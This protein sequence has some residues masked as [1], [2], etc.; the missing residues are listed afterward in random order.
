MTS[1]THY[2]K[3]IFSGMLAT[4]TSL[5][6]LSPAQ[7]E[8]YKWVDAQGITHYSDER[9]ANKTI[10]ITRIVFKQSP[11]KRNNNGKATE[12]G[13]QEVLTL[14]KQSNQPTNPKEKN[15]SQTSATQNLDALQQRKTN[16]A[17]GRKR[18]CEQGR[19][20]LAILRQKIPLYLDNNEQYRLNWAGDTYTG[21]RNYLDDA[22]RETAIEKAEKVIGE[23]CSDPDDREAQ[24]MARKK[25]AR[26]EYCALNRAILSD[27]QRADIKASARQLTTQQELTDKYCK[28]NKMSALAE[29]PELLIYPR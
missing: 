4:Y 14:D 28:A 11:T 16:I 25:W 22:D 26:S 9:P 2:H 23:Y 7:A 29:E 18:R 17:D 15:N 5:L 21:E 3:L 8:I 10:A 24:A 1:K 27:L 12:S 19:T 13:T 20:D 6:H